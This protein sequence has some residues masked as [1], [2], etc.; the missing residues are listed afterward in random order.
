M[1]NIVEHVEVEDLY[2]AVVVR[3]HIIRICYD[4]GYPRRGLNW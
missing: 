1:A 4:K 3:I 2:E